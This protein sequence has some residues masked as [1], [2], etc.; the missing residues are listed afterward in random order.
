ME[1]ITT[2]GVYVFGFLSA[3]VVSGGRRPKVDRAVT[4]LS[5][6]LPPSPILPVGLGVGDQRALSNLMVATEEIISKQDAD[7]D[8]KPMTMAE[9][10]ALIDEMT[11]K[12]FRGEATPEELH[13]TWRMADKTCR[14]CGGR[15]SR[16]TDD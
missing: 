1:L 14:R 10:E 12:M 16:Y 8:W 11:Q 5:V 2:I 7:P 3:L 13:A 9:H 6:T 15:H 4:G